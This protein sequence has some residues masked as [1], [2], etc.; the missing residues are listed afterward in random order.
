MLTVS[1]ADHHAS[2]SNTTSPAGSST[3][4]R[5][6]S[7]LSIISGLGWPVFL[8]LG[9]TTLFFVL[10]HRGPLNHPLMH[11][12]FASHPVTYCETALFFIGMAALILKL[13][14]VA[15]QYWA[16]GRVSLRPVKTGGDSLSD[17]PEL[18]A[19][20]NELP[21]GVRK[22]H[23]ARRLGDALE[24]VRRT[25][26]A[27]Q[28][29]DELKYLADVEAA[30]QQESYSLVRIVIWATPMLGFLGTV[31]GITE[32]LGDLSK[33]AEL[34]ATSIDTAIQGLLGGLYVAF[35]T[36]ALALTLSML[37]MFIQF[38]I[39]RVEQQLLSS[40]DR[41]AN[42]QL[43]G[44]FPGLVTSSDP[45]V[46]MAERLLQVLSRGA[47]Q[48]SQRQAEIWQASLAKAEQ[49][50]QSMFR[51]ASEQMTANLT[52]HHEEWERSCDVLTR[53]LQASSDVTGL[54]RALNSNLAALANTKNF[55]DMVMSL[56]AAIH[57]LTTRLSNTPETI[58]LTDRTRLTAEELRVLRGK[59]A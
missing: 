55:E 40:V 16:F 6:P 29:A 10:I 12:Y 56:N 25:G 45:Q 2:E 21:A 9:A 7:L 52:T 43:M 51:V 28:L 53:A 33:N 14:E 4:T 17:C 44:R 20:L 19:E 13:A 34:L 58:A 11:R 42:E 31:M 47:E 8:G 27:E 38:V 26:S 3:E 18:L 22:S 57:L 59:A 5:R 37:L 39:D 46:A 36:T 41:A 30:A 23:L 1:H 24:M 35:D 49:Q 54:E 48:L 32:A 50:W 15:G